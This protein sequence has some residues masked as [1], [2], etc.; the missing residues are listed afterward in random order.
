MIDPFFSPPLL[1][2]NVYVPTL[3]GVANITAVTP[4]AAFFWQNGPF[5]L[6]YFLINVDPILG[7]P[8]ATSFRMSLPIASAL[9]VST[10]LTGTAVRISSGTNPFESAYIEGVAATDDAGIFFNA[11]NT[12][13][14][15]MYGSFMY[16]IV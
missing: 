8:T 12:S 1:Q 11:V 15:S 16:Q 7:A 4:L 9:S 6:V 5:V 3:T 13:N 14:T 2:S 10:Q